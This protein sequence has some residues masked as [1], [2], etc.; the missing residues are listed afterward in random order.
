MCIFCVKLQK[1]NDTDVHHSDRSHTL[2]QECALMGFCGHGVSN[3]YMLPCALPTSPHD[4]LVGSVGTRHY[5]RVWPCAFYLHI[6]SFH[7]SHRS[8]ALQVLAETASECGGIL[9]MAHEK[10]APPLCRRWRL[11]HPRGTRI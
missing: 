10:R 2:F 4:D 11:I 6:F 3:S 8:V 9:T 7:C 1:P 5:R